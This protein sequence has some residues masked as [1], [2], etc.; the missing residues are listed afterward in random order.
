MP[1]NRLLLARVTPAEK[2]AVEICA[3]ARAATITDLIRAKVVNPSVRW[4]A[5]ERG[6]GGAWQKGIKL[7]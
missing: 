5:K 1:K 6:K 4:L 2:E 7:K 3:A